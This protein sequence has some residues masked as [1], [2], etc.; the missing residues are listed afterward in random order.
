MHWQRT[1][2]LWLPQSLPSDLTLHKQNYDFSCTS[3]E[4]MADLVRLHAGANVMKN[5]PEMSLKLTCNDRVKAR[6]TADGRQVTL[7]ERLA[8]GGVS[9]ALA[10]ARV[11]PS[12]YAVPSSVLPSLFCMHYVHMA[13][14]HIQALLL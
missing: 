8:I 5:V 13:A 1:L 11:N 9:G 3:S 7:A 6:F 14:G 12:A 4:N 2:C 10:Q